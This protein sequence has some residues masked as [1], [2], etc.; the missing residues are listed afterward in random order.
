MFLAKLARNYCV[1]SDLDHSVYD[2]IRISANQMSREKGTI[3]LDFL[4]GRVLARICSLRTYSVKLTIHNQ[5][6]YRNLTSVS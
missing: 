1:V 5:V 4:R 3:W 6:G 2:L